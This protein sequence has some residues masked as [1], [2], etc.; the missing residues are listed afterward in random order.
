MTNDLILALII[1]VL[2]I[3]GYALLQILWSRRVFKFP[4]DDSELRGPEAHATALKN[5]DL[6]FFWPITGPAILIIIG[7]RK[8]RR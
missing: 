2:W 7:I 4:W 8:I 3:G 1:I 6:M 5:T